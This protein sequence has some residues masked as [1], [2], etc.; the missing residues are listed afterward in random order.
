MET[1]KV[2]EK[3]SRAGG[4]AHPR[5]PYSLRI[6]LALLA[7][8]VLLLA[9]GLVGFALNSAN[10]SGAVSSLQIRMESY[11]Y[12][13][14]A[15]MEVDVSGQVTIEELAD[16]R[17]NL[18]GSGHYL[19]VKGQNT[20]WHSASELGITLP[21]PP[22]LGTGESS[23][24]EPEAP[25]E[26]FIYAYGIGWQLPDGS[27]EPFTVSVW[28]EASE[29]RSQTAAFRLGL[30]QSL[31]TAGAILLLAQVLILFLVFRPLGR[32]ARDVAK[33]ESGRS[34]RLEGD[35]PRE[36]EPLARNVNRLLE[37]EKSNQER[38]R[39]ALDS[40]AHSLKTPLAVIQAGLPLH[41]GKA[42]ASMQNAVDEIQHL[43]A[44]RLERAGS[45]AR[46]TMAEPVPVEPQLQRIVDSL[47]KVY[48]QK[49]IE[50]ELIMEKD[51]VFHGEKRD[52]LE[53][54]GNLADNAYKYGDKK[55]R[56]SAGASG[57]GQSRPGLWIRVEDDGPGI[58]RARRDAL[59][60]RGVRGDERVEGHGLGL[61]I[62]L[63]LVTA[64][65]GDIEIGDSALGGARIEVR[66]PA[67]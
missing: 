30:W 54:I 1:R 40:L 33:V 26:Y 61:A 57:P 23:F 45:S 46:R 56:I 41:G 59:L 53:L 29:L 32:V 48:S 39:N 2:S 25:D 14:L 19:V 38:I 27:I 18:P 6:R 47:G 58:D 42:E 13:A 49:M 5:R 22:V 7:T 34:T 50:P 43:V 36:L 62:V 8:I 67:T 9:L 20:D 28:V 10:Y 24:T 3:E 63:E 21:A 65:G 4:S 16:P 60:Q 12:Q 11:V 44:T 64:Y 31:A 35:Y 17:L 51:L 15:A 55:V 37:T 66:I 52:L